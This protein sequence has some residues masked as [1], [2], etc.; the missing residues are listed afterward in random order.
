MHD[1][2]PFRAVCVPVDVCMSASEMSVN[3]RL[4]VS[5]AAAAATG[6]AVCPPPQ[7]SSRDSILRRPGGE[8]IEEER[9]WDQTGLT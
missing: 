5:A 4:C 8:R 6:A 9:G 2:G 7:S 1:G 3:V